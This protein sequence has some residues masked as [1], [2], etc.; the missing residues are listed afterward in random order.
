MTSREAMPHI[1]SEKLKKSL[2]LPDHTNRRQRFLIHLAKLELDDKSS[3][4]I[5]CHTVFLG[6][7]SISGISTNRNQRWLT[8]SFESSIAFFGFSA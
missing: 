5:S 4:Y 1:I 2:G 6:L 7:E 3:E 8:A